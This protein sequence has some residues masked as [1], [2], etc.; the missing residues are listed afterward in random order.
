[1]MSDVSFVLPA[2]T[3]RN[4]WVWLF[5]GAAVSAFFALILVVLSVVSCPS[6]NNFHLRKILCLTGI[7]AL[8]LA[9]R[10]AHA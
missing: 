9:I 7:V 4:A 1:M 10:K 6:G 2:G 3:D 5:D 8:R